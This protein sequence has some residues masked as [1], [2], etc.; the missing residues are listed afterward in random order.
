MVKKEI[1]TID[2]IPKESPAPAT[3]PKLRGGSTKQ[4]TRRSQSMFQTKHK[5][6]KTFAQELRAG[7]RK[8]L[9]KKTHIGKANQKYH[10]LVKKLIKQQQKGRVSAI[11]KGSLIDEDMWSALEREGI[12]KKAYR[13]KRFIDEVIVNI[14]KCLGFAEYIKLSWKHAKI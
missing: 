1:I 5:K 7:S 11:V 10:T 2:E 14:R 3:D 13:T 9:M 4:H 8:A 12:Q 6:Y